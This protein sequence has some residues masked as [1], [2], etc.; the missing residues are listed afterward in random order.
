MARAKDTI[1]EAIA[2]AEESFAGP[3]DGK[4]EESGATGSRID[5]PAEDKPFTLTDKDMRDEIEKTNRLWAESNP[6]PD[7]P[8]PLAPVSPPA[9]DYL[10][11]FEPQDV[12]ADIE[13]KTNDA[14][15]CSA[16]E[17]MYPDRKWADVSREDK[18][19]AIILAKAHRNLMVGFNQIIAAWK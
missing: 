18:A 13:R 17:H 16:Y 4:P 6:P 1:S 2:G 9:T 11:P 7:Q 14:M 8:A 15:F 10:P 19:N 3:L 5:G 12:L